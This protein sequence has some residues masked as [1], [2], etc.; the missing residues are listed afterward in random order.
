MAIEFRMRNV[1]V[2]YNLI[3]H[4]IDTLFLKAPLTS[5][6]TKFGWLKRA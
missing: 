2:Y 3:G 5:S 6:V 4:F 1:F